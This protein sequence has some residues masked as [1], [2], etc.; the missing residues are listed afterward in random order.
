MTDGE[1][2]PQHEEQEFDFS[3]LFEDGQDAKTEPE[4]G[5]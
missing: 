1:M 5:G 2:N 3:Y 4:R